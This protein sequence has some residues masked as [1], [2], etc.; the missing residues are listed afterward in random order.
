MVF[1][2][3]IPSIPAT[4]GNFLIPLM[5]GARDLAFPRINLLSWYLFM[6]GAGFAAYSLI[7]GGVDTGWTF[8]TPYSTAFSNTHVVSAAMGAFIAGFSSILTGLNF[9]V[10]IHK[11]RAPGLTW[12]RLPLFVWATYA[13]SVI[14]MLATP[15]LAI[16]PSPSTATVAATAPAAPTSSRPM[17]GSAIASSSG[18]CGSS[19]PSARSTT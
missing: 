12:F 19:K 11:M 3:L 9:I 2:F 7:S 5:I 4:L 17:R 8:Y 1:F 10:T 6:G 16:T 13:T 15:V 18:A 14:I